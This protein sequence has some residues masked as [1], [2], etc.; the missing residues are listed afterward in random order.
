M[1]LYYVRHGDPTY[2]PDQLTPLGHMQAH[3]V[4]KRLASH[5]ID[6]IYCSTSTRAMETAQPLCDILKKK[7]ILQDW[8]NEHYAFMDLSVPIP[9]N[10]RLWAIM[11]PESRKQLFSKEVLDLGFQ[12]YDHPDFADTNFKAGI[13]RIQRETDAFLESL[14]YARDE[15]LRCYRQLRE[16]NERIALFAHDGVGGGILSH[17]LGFPYPQYA[18]RFSMG[19]STVTVLEFKETQGVV[20]PSVRCFSNDSHLYRDGYPTRY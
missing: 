8:C 4:A 1:L 19:V 20:I 13:Q 10:D 15:E 6:R 14:G 17:I 18:L 2:N 16:N 12:W 9:N 5:G 7:M 11:V 3:S